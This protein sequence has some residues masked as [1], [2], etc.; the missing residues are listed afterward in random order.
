MERRRSRLRRR[1]RGLQLEQLETRRLLAT[2]AVTTTLD[3]VDTDPGNG[4]CEIAG[5]GCSLRAA[6]QEA[7]GLG[8]TGGPH[9]INLPAGTYSLT[10]EGSDESGSLTGDLNIRAS[11]SIVGS[12]SSDTIIDGGGLDRVIDAVLG[13]VTI[14]A[15]TIR[16]GFVDAEEESFEFIGGGIRNQA[17][18]LLLDSV[19]TG[20]TAGSGG[21]VANYGGSLTIRRST[22]TGNG[23]EST[24]RG[25]GVFNYANYD[26]A[27]VV[28][29]ES[30]IA[31]NRAT[32]GGGLLN[33]AY[34]GIANTII[35][36][37]TISANN[38]L[39]G[40]G[41]A[42]LSTIIFDDASQATL[43][44]RNSTISGNTAS[45][46]GGGVHNQSKYGG[47]SQ[48]DILNSTITLNA[49]TA[50]DGGGIRSVDAPELATLIRSTIV[51]A[52]SAGR[53]GT[54]LFGQSIAG[55]FNLVGD[56]NG[57]PLVN[58]EDNNL[59]GLDPVLGPLA[60]NGGETLT[61]SLLDG[62]PAI[63]QGTNSVG[64]TSDQRGTAFQRTIDV[65]ASGNASD[66]TDIGAVEVGGNVPIA[67]ADLE[68]GQSVDNRSPVIGERVTFTITVTNRGPDRATNVEVTNLL[69]PELLFES[70]T[71]TQGAYEFE[72]TWLVGT[73]EPNASA[74]LRIQATVASSDTI[75]HTAE[76]T[77]SD[78]FDPD[79]T[80]GNGISGEDDQATVTLGTC[81]S[82]GPLHVGLNRLTFSCASPGAWVGFVHGTLVGEKT[83]D[84]YDVT[85]DIADAEGVA[86]AFADLQG[87]ATVSLTLSQSQLDE[88]V[89]AFADPL[90]VQAFEMLPR[91]TKS[92]M[93]VLSDEVDMLRATNLG[94]GSERIDANSIRP[95]AQAAVERWSQAT[96]SREQLARLNG[97]RILISDLPGNA[98]ARVIGR[99]IIVDVDA[100][101]N[102]WFVDRSPGE[103]SEYVSTNGRGRMDAIDV[104]ARQRIDLLTTLIHEYGHMLALPDE[105]TDGNGVMSR[106]LDVGLRRLPGPNTNLDEP[107]DVNGDGWVTALDALQIINWLGRRSLTSG[108]V[109][110]P[111]L[112]DEFTASI[113]LDTNADFRVT[114]GDALLIINSMARRY[115]TAA[116][117]EVSES[118][119]R[120]LA[121]IHL[122][123]D[124]AETDDMLSSYRPHQAEFASACWA[125]PAGR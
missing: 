70:A 97:A 121:G 79:S 84:Q 45:G 26:S 75:A 116:E 63:D 122:D 59:V 66:G 11:M 10:L 25:G 110:P 124:S 36:Q 65:A 52:N 73:L 64:L 47:E 101:G 4:V 60:D 39:I 119:L 16:G 31:D 53:E 6:I 3:A 123:I 13:N 24:S 80:P 48:A 32:N 50:L 69:P 104:D 27:T 98:L 111:W 93:L 51:A 118:D 95:I 78:Q 12:G 1:R 94:P 30:T 100:A 88:L 87:V 113:F 44:V 40:G 23:D 106:Q 15:V 7:N 57:H 92:N 58:G 22:I 9:L 115:P 33:F 105:A 42:N 76:I 81:L 35:Q 56:A 86:V 108:L 18:L 34:D 99:T 19:V 17:D 62:S 29:N 74:E 20:N 72:E 54:D 38:A 77:A 67:T 109:D 125:G 82:G 83:F 2:L 21:G 55:T 8:E 91:R 103:D 5:G 14:Q 68:L 89:A 46:S 117:S 61:H 71:V 96:L 49:A 120:V 114:A 28:I 41:I 37:S 102:G 85:V 43:S 112:G 107:M 90:L